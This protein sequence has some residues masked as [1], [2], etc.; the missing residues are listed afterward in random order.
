VARRRAQLAPPNTH[1]RSILRD[2]NGA[3]I[4]EIGLDDY[5]LQHPDGSISQHRV[6]DNIQLVD[7]L[8]WNPGMLITKP[9]TYVGICHLCRHPPF[10]GLRREPATHGIV[11][12]ARA[13]MCFRCGILCCPR[14]R[15]NVSGKWVCLSCA[16]K[17]HIKDFFLSLLFRS[18][19]D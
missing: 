18:E 3:V 1:S 12:L 14:H 16:G 7:G 5:L 10:V 17:S 11:S 15:R 6:S 8:I 13:K 19:E 4:L 2:I 9:P